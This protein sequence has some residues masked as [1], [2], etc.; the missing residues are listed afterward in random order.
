MKT[1]VEALPVA[2][3]SGE[4]QEAAVC[5]FRRGSVAAVD[6]PLEETSRVG[7]ELQQPHDRLLGQLVQLKAPPVLITSMYTTIRMIVQ[8]AAKTP[9]ITRIQ[10]CHGHSASKDAITQSQ[11]VMSHS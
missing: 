10:Q 11:S 1:E 4:R 6:N 3:D 5:D 2:E 7:V 8:L 9:C